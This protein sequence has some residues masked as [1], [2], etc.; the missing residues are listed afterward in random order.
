M[1]F[2]AEKKLHNIPK[3]TKNCANT[4]LLPNK[5]NSFKSFF[6]VGRPNFSI[7]WLILLYYTGIGTTIIGMTR[8]TYIEQCLESSI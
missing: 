2:T 6:A 5:P 4:G 7:N 1:H 8:K 3:V